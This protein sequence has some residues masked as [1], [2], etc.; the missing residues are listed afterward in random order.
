M[1]ELSFWV[2]L[3]SQLCTSLVQVL[4]ILPTLNPTHA[5]FS[6]TTSCPLRSQCLL[7][8][9]TAFSFLLCLSCTSSP[10]SAN[11]ERRCILFTSYY[12]VSYPHITPFSSF[13]CCS[14][15]P[16]DIRF[17]TQQVS[18]HSPNEAMMFIANPRAI[19]IFLWT[20][21]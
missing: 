6:S 9:T 4:W 16:G 15:L 7:F 17:C 13:L 14:S 10:S 8:C 21:N 12:F 11:I 2:E 18:R 19:R 20:E 5:P 3:T 1:H